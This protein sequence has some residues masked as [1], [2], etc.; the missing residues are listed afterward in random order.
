[1]SD[2]RVLIPR[3]KRWLSMLGSCFSPRT[4]LNR[5]ISNSLQQLARRIGLCARGVVVG[6]K[7]TIWPTRPAVERRG[8]VPQEVRAQ[9]IVIACRLPRQEHV[10]LSRWSRAELA[11]RVALHPALSRISAGTVDRWLK[12]ERLRPWRFHAWQHIHAPHCKQRD[13]LMDQ[14]FRKIPT[15]C[16]ESL[17]LQAFGI[18]HWSG[19]ASRRHLAS[20]RRCR[21]PSGLC[22][23]YPAPLRDRHSGGASRPYAF[24]HLAV[25][26]TA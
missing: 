15:E 25:M 21:V 10:P 4:I 1:M 6:R 17:V 19:R 18:L 12:A 22:P 23:C 11:R 24:V 26:A 20:P 13:P 2:W 7:R 5:A 8:V 3:L 14:E 16:R 9:V